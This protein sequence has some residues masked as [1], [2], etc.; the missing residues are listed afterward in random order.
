[1][2]PLAR[3]GID[4][5]LMIGLKQ[6]SG[7]S[8]NGFTNCM[9]AYIGFCRILWISE[10]PL[11]AIPISLTFFFQLNNLEYY[12]ECLENVFNN[13]RLFIINEQITVL[14]LNLPSYSLTL[15]RQLYIE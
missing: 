8:L 6:S 4:D 13:F 10:F 7:K 9:P 5:S 14:I 12:L 1:M 11:A 15:A 3:S 2:N